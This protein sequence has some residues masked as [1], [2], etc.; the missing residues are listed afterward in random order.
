MKLYPLKF[1]PIPVERKWGGTTL[2]EMLEKRFTVTDED[3]NE[4]ELPSYTVIGESLEVADLGEGED[5]EVSEGFLAGNSLGEITD[6]YME[7]LIGDN[8][9]Q[10][11]GTQFPLSIKIMD[12]NGRMPVHVHPDDE[13]AFER[14]DAL[15]KSEFWYILEAG[16]N[17]AVYL[18]PDR[19]LSASDFFE[20]CMDGSITAS[21]KRIT[22]RRGDMIRIR[23]GTLHFAEGGIVAAVIEE[24][25]QV[26]F[27]AFDTDQ[28]ED[29]RTASLGEMLD[30]VNLT[31]SDLT[32]CIVKGDGTVADD[33]EFT[34][35]KI[36]LD[37]KAL[38]ISTEEFDSMLIYI[39]V[40]GAAVIECEP[41]GSDIRH[42]LK[43]GEVIVVPAAAN[44]VTIIPDRQGCTVL[45]ARIE[46]RE[47][48]DSYIKDD[49]ADNRNPS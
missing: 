22:P 13:V 27:T 38:N 19:E 45:E 40:E 3:G 42:T 17:A 12:I 35:S 44:E 4:S 1:K 21:M 20:M 41:D 10:Y 15:G 6:T 30:F 5:T 11:F 25:S 8:V 24:A 7:N 9:S 29:D 34:V 14:Y 18:G 43:R 26:S 2:H 47:E 39:C 32:T 28:N 36:R 48:K 16:E 23:P 46:K 49:A 31:P 33:R 37:S